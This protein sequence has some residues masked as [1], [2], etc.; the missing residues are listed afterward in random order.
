MNVT[1][2]GTRGSQ[3]ALWQAN[4]VK[5]LLQQQHPHLDI[6]L[7][8]IKTQGD[9][10]LDRPLSE[11]GGKGLF[12]KELEVAMLEDRIDLAVHSMKDLPAEL[13]EGLEISTVLPR[14]NP[15]D[16]LV[17]KKGDS[18]DELA[19]SARI[20]TSS[21][22]RASQVL[23]Y[24]PQVT[25]LPLRGNVDTRIQKIFNGEEYD[26]GILAY[27]GIKRL[28]LEKYIS[29]VLPFSLMLPAIAQGIIGI[30]NRIEDQR[31][32]SYLQPLHHEETYLCMQAEREVLK[33]LEGNCNVPIAGYCQKFGES[34]TLE[35]LLAHPDGSEVI[36][37]KQQ[38]SCESPLVLGQT[39]AQEVL[40]QG[41]KQMLTA[42]MTTH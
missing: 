35:A 6:E 31:T 39:V 21:L 2:I 41:G 12:V 17:S 38:H 18:L 40:R 24:Q 13:P 4:H 30:E 8:V 10:I 5:D 20:G 32:K 42:I 34:L 1:R 16:V 33:M 3:L 26:A 29:Q 7:V 9:R 25:I 14:E 19:Q 15:A 36:H 11:I 23:A 28:G 27:A 22:R 37:V